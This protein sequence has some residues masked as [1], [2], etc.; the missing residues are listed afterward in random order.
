VRNRFLSQD[1]AN[2]LVRALR[3]DPNRTAARSIL[4]ILLTG[5]RRNEITY[6][7]WTDLLVERKCLLVP[8]AKSGRPR[9]I[10]LNEPAL[11][12][13]SQIPRLADNPY[14]FPSPVTGRPSPSLHFPWRRIRRNAGL[15]EDLRLHDLRHS[16]ASFL[17]GRGV[18][19]YVVQQ[20][21]GHLHIRTTQ[22][23]CHLTPELLEQGANALNDVFDP[24]E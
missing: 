22:R 4:L 16:F 15:P 11:N 13:L 23:Y 2:R 24:V 5:A 20:L 19:L 1:E 17:V 21:L 14:I 9:L 12:L 8:L 3:A 6:A 18:S 7:R 10:V